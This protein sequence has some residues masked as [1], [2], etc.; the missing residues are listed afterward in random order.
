MTRLRRKLHERGI[1]SNISPA[2]ATPTALPSSDVTPRSAQS[3]MGAE[4]IVCHSPLALGGK[5]ASLSSPVSPLS[6][7]ASEG[8]LRRREER[9]QEAEGGGGSSSGGGER[10]WEEKGSASH[11]VAPAT[12]D[13]SRAG[14]LE[15][16]PHAALATNGNR[17]GGST[18]DDGGIRSAREG[19]MLLVPGND[20]A[21]QEMMRLSGFARRSPSPD[22]LQLRKRSPSPEVRDF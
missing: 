20:R 19:E 15:P 1:T 13:S 12:G 22:V 11:G 9:P 7:S 5:L 17:W 8:I 3:D 4:G 2:S 21:R 6:N 18:G 10:I 14:P 16:L